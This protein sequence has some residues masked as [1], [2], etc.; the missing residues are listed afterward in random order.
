MNAFR[1]N[2]YALIILEGF[3]VMALIDTV[4]SIYAFDSN[5]RNSFGTL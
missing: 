2:S 1:G 3:D 5:S 4:D